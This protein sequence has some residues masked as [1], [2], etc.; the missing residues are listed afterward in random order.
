MKKSWI[1]LL[2]AALYS[3]ARY[4]TQVEVSILFRELLLFDK[5]EIS[6]REA[7]RLA[8][9]HSTVVLVCCVDRDATALGWQA[10]K[11]LKPRKL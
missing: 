7:Q 6:I 11:I 4:S 9:S 3:F 5:I 8:E 10:E 2:Y 1:T